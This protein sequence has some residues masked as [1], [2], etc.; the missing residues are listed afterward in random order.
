MGIEQLSVPTT[1]NWRM[2]VTPVPE[3]TALDFAIGT[4][5]IAEAADVTAEAMHWLG[6]EVDKTKTQELAA[7][8]FQQLTEAIP[9]DGR[10]YVLPAVGFEYLLAAAEGR[11]PKRIESVARHQ[12]TW[13][14]GKG[15]KGRYTSDQLNAGPEKHVAR[16]A[17][18]RQGGASFEPTL[19]YLADPRTGQPIPYDDYARDKWNQGALTTQLKELGYDKKAFANRYPDSEL[20]ATD[21]KA[22][23]MMRLMD[24]IRGENPTNPLDSKSE[25]FILNQGWMRL[26]NLGRET[27]DG[28]S[29]VAS[30]S[31]HVGRA[32]FDRDAGLASGIAGVGLSAGRKVS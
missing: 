10:L 8:D 6:V 13:R 11:K 24:L 16:L 26:P 27:V 2:P 7:T 23:L 15:I 9:Y 21:Q 18:F 3:R 17:I 25:H 30:V 22:Y 29:V 1:E 31:S 4:P 5:G 12:P 28:R 32:R 14:D 19:H 20:N